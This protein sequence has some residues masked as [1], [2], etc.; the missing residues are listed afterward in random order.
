M[1]NGR[2]AQFQRDITKAMTAHGWK[3]GTTDGYDRKGE[4]VG[5]LEL[6]HYRLTKR[7]EERL[8]LAVAGEGYGLTSVSDVR[9]GKPHDLEKQR[10]TEIIDRH[11]DLNGAEASDDDKLHFANGIGDRIG[12]DEAVTAQVLNHSEVQMMHD[13]SPRR[14]LTPCS[15]SS[16]NIRG[17]RAEICVVDTQVAGG[18]VSGKCAGKQMSCR[19]TG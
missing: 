7:E 19:L 11:N 13:S 18:Q 12:R 9:S 17:N 16:A 15:T 2:V 8:R 14:S 10:L 4:D 1:A 5:G 6:T 3:A